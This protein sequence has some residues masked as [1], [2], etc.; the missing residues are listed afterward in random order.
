M[1]DGDGTMRVPDGP[2]IGVVP[3]PERLEACTLRREVL[4]A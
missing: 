4:E 2:G 1:L 3:F